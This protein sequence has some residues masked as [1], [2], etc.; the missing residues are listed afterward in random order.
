[1]GDLRTGI[2]RGAAL[3]NGLH[4]P[5]L[6]APWLLLLPALL[7][8]VVLFLVPLAYLVA[9][10]FRKF[11]LTT[12]VGGFT[13]DNYVRLLT[14]PFY[15]RVLATTFRLAAIAAVLC[16]L[17]G[18]PLALLL[19]AAP[20]RL[21]GLLIVG[22]VAPLLVSVIVRTFGWVVILGEFGLLNNA[23]RAIGVDATFARSSHLF[24]EPAVIAGL[25]HVFLPFMV[26]AI[27][28]ALQKQQARVVDAARN[29]GAS[30]LRAFV[31]VTLPLSLPGVVAGLTTVF[32]MATGAYITVAVLGGSR[33]MVMSIL[34]Y[35]QSLGLA[36][37]QMGAAIGI[38]LLIGTMTVMQL[39]QIVMR[40]SFPQALQA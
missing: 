34:A 21:K 39:F 1:V 22:I 40:R 27:H 2:R 35:Q 29:L 26:L 12:G 33:V 6:L 9:D 4:R 16:L 38:V 3:L 15:L 11:S 37:W 30:P 20:A 25:V 8:L 18:Y 23:L 19:R 5:R 7:A 17:L 24:N 31:L 13:L 36:N 28:G 14:D 10:S 32:A